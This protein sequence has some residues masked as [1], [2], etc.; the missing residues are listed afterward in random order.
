MKYSEESN[1]TSQEKFF[2]DKDKSDTYSDTAPIRHKSYLSHIPL[3]FDPFAY[4]EIYEDVYAS[5]ES[6]QFNSPEEHYIQHGFSEGRTIK[7]SLVDAVSISEFDEETYLSLYPDVRK[8]CADGLF[9]SG[10][11]HWKAYA[12]KEKR[13]CPLFRNP[14]MD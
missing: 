14:F 4:Q 12:E 11:A 5:L 3:D 7:R 2:I 1:C 9:E 8:A 10:Y 6:G 13:I